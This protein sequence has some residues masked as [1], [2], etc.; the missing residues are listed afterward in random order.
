ML[1]LMI[2]RTR[3]SRSEEGNAM[4]QKYSARTENARID[5]EIRE[6]D[7]KSILE[8]KHLLMGAIEDFDR[9]LVKQWN[10]LEEKS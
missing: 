8:A 10:N 6:R 3:M 1:S 9:E 4:L 7:I 2:F 5:V